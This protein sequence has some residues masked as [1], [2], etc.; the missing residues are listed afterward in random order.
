[1]SKEFYILA[2]LWIISIITLL[3]ISKGK[4]RLTQ[5]TFLFTQALAWVF[6]YILVFFK[7]V[8]FPYREFEVATKMSFSLYYVIFPVVGVL[9]ILFYPT[10]SRKGKVFFYYLF[11]SMLIPTFSSFAEKYTKLFLFVNWNWSV[12]VLAD[13]IIFYILKQFIFW[14]RRGIVS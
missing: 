13:L 10:T 12:H 4:M 5:I 3:S 11:F 8:E 6:E 7:L 2:F 9:F 14:F 1:M